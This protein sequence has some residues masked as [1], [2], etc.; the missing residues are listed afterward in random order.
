MGRHHGGVE[1]QETA[2]QRASRLLAEELKHRGWDEAELRRRKIG[3]ADQVETQV[4]PQ[5][6]V[7]GQGLER[8]TAR[9]A[10]IAE[11]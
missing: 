10:A 1:R 11:H 9:F 7:A 8:S 4:T 5:V 6:V 3:L 2:E